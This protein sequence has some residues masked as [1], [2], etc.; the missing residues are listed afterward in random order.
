[1][2]VPSTSRSGIRWGRE[3]TWFAISYFPQ[4]RSHILRITKAISKQPVWNYSLAK[5]FRSQLEY[6]DYVSVPHPPPTNT[7]HKH[8]TSLL[9]CSWLKGPDGAAVVFMVFIGYRF[10]RRSLL[11]RTISS[12]I[13]GVHCVSHHWN[14]TSCL[15]HCTNVKVAVSCHSCVHS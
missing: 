3:S 15:L 12:A 8:F 9:T 4:G 13:L 6:N 14:Y 2:F 10:V 7:H 1:M 5:F 11:H